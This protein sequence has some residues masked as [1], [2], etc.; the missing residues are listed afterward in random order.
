MLWRAFTCIDCDAVFHEGCGAALP[1]DLAVVLTTEA[2]MSLEENAAQHALHQRKATADTLGLLANFNSK[3][4]N[5]FHSVAKPFAMRALQKQQ[6]SLYIDA[7]LRLPDAKLE[8]AVLEDTRRALRFAIASYGT[9]YEQGCMSDAFSNV[10]MRV[11]FRD[12]LAPKAETNN[13]AVARILGLP[14]DVVLHAAWGKTVCE[15]SYC[16]VLDEAAEEV[17]LAFRGSLS[18]ADFLTDAC[19]MPAP[20]CG[21][22][23]HQ[24][25]CE[26][27]DRVVKDSALFDCLRHALTVHRGFKLIIAGHSLGAG[28]TTLFTMRLLHERLLGDDPAF[29]VYH[30]PAMSEEVRAAMGLRR[31]P[32]AD[33]L[34]CDWCHAYAFAPPPVV[35]LPLADQFDSCITSVVVAKDVVPRLSLTSVDRLGAK[36]AQI[37]GASAPGVGAGH[38]VD[39]V[40]ETFIPGTV[41]L[42]TKP[43]HVRTRLVRVDRRSVLL[44]D[45]FLSSS[46]VVNHIP[47]QYAQALSVIAAAA[48]TP[49]AAAA[50]AG[51]NAGDGAA[52]A[53]ATPEQDSLFA[54]DD[55]MDTEGFIVLGTP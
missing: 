2:R 16:V 41:L 50:V 53:P 47:D 29:R 26:M 48:R 1:A 44:R 37:G 19:G 6:A 15:P 39:S 49:A 17:V 51:G 46:M 34:A 3:N 35:T 20:F 40:E 11:A 36:L 23:A 42:S 43:N 30:P 33:S 27:V 38:F 25:M 24:G 32:P 8:P 18:D 52:D 12:L 45:I 13:D 7:C 55:D 10:M 14:R 28:L 9:A 31:F 22:M 4:K 21:G 54:T 5:W